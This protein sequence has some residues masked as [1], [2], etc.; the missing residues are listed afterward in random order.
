MARTY[1]GAALR[2]QQVSKRISR[3]KI[4]G[5]LA[6]AVGLAGAGYV[7][8]QTIDVLSDLPEEDI[9]FL[10]VNEGDRSPQNPGIY[11]EFRDTVF[12]LYPLQADK[13][14]NPTKLIRKAHSKY[15]PDDNL[16]PD[17]V[18]RAEDLFNLVNTKKINLNDIVNNGIK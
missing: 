5:V 16:D 7:A 12:R 1:Q 4:L 9:Y 17:L 8:K 13:K 14:D 10:K 15:D 3:R 2:Q 11:V 18:L 6:A